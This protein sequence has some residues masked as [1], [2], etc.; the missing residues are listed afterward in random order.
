MKNKKNRL[1]Q[2]AKTENTFL[3]TGNRK[4]KIATSCSHQAEEKVSSG[5]DERKYKEIC[6]VVGKNSLHDEMCIHLDVIVVFSLAAK[7]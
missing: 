3:I 5:K 6:I 4:G 7:S 1:N 2:E